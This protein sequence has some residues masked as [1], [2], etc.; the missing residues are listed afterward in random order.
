M[1]RTWLFDL[2]NTLHDASPHIF[3]HINRSMRAYIERRLPATD[4]QAIRQRRLLEALY[5]PGE[6]QLDYD[7]RLTRDA[8]QAFAER[9]GNCLSLVL[10]TAAFARELGL[11]VQFN[12]VDTAEPWTLQGD[13]LLRSHHVN[14]SLVDPL[15]AGARGA[16]L[17]LTVDFLPGVD[18]QRARMRPI[19][20]PRVLAMFYNN[21]AAETLAEGRVDEAYWLVRAALGQDADF[22]PAHNTLG[23]VYQRAGRLALAAQVFEQLL[24]VRGEDPGVLANL[25]LVRRAQGRLADAAGL[26]ARLAAVEPRPP[27][28][29]GPRGLTAGL[30]PKDLAGP[31]G[32]PMKRLQ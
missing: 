22:A 27:A 9:R 5:A 32:Q 13:L 23:V 15:A 4:R 17:S 25:V 1:N 11:T 30:L 7:A 26:Q 8:A 29:D 2:D 14:L 19:E 20:L 10:M 6:L 16:A 12:E 18:L 31:D 3:P 24:A 21:R 28:G